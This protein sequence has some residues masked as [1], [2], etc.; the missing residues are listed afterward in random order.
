M[1]CAC[2]LFRSS[3]RLIC[4]LF[5]FVFQ[6]ELVESVSEIYIHKNESGRK[7]SAGHRWSPR[8]GERILQNSS[9]ERCQGK[10]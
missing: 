9:A 4:V 3:F 7:S 6:R 1:T 2:T 5:M 8:S 10:L